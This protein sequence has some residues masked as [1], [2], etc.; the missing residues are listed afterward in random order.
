MCRTRTRR[1]PPFAIGIAAW[2][3]YYV[4]ATCTSSQTQGVVILL[5]QWM[6]LYILSSTFHFT[7][8][9]TLPLA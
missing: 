9:R 4:Y 1:A 6:G 8:I 5:D 2:Q 3:R 7:T